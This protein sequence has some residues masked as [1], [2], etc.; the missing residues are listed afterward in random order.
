MRIAGWCGRLLRF[1]S[2]SQKRFFALEHAPFCPKQA[3]SE[4]KSGKNEASFLAEPLPGPIFTTPTVPCPSVPARAMING[5][6]K[7]PPVTRGR[8]ECHRCYLV[9]IASSKGVSSAFARTCDV[10]VTEKFENVNRRNRRYF[11]YFI[12]KSENRK[13]REWLFIHASPPDQTNIST[14][15]IHALLA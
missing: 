14:H 13:R 2:Y 11:L 6:S 1:E 5:L 9:S 12:K 7:N 4:R 15:Y 10:F 3:H 8:L